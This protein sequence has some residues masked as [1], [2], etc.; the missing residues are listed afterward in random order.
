MN[1]RSPQKE[2]S[3][4]RNKKHSRL[5]HQRHASQ[6]TTRPRRHD[7]CTQTT[8]IDQGWNQST[9]QGGGP[10]TQTFNRN[11]QMIAPF[12]GRAAILLT[13]YFRLDDREDGTNQLR[14]GGP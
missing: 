10:Q 9:P 14:R 3:K 2:Q 4:Y 6:P 11:G 5:S 13:L 1:T 8:E 7:S 12:H